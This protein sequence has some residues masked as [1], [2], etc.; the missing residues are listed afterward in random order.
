MT[1][2]NE[3]TVELAALEYLRQLGFSTAFGPDLAADG[4]APE[5]TSYGQVYLE[6]RLREAMRRINPGLSPDVVDEAI[7]RLFRPESQ[8][9]LAENFRVHKLLTYGVPI[10]HRASDGSVR[11]TSVRLIDFEYPENN[12]WLAVNQFTIVE[13]NRSRR[14]DVLVFQTGPLPEMVT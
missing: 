2:L 8:N 14:P 6:S 10:E 5:R 9:P 11:T 13:N 12:D 1:T 7:K 4:T 3:S